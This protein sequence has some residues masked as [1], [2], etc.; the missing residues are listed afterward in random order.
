MRR[1][2]PLCQGSRSVL[3]GF[4]RQTKMFKLTQDYLDVAGMIVGDQQSRRTW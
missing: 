2:P 1:L 4:G 3:R